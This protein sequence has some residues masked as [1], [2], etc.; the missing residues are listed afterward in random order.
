LLHRGK[1]VGAAEIVLMAV[2][3][4]AAALAQFAAKAKWV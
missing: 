3:K 4:M 1:S 2:A